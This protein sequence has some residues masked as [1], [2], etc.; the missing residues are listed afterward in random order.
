MSVYIYIYIY[1]YTYNIYR[2]RERERDDVS[3]PKWWADNPINNCV[4]KRLRTVK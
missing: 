3:K 1:I 4:V 2:E